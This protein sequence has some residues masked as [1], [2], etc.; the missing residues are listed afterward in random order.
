MKV[1]TMPSLSST[2]LFDKHMKTQL[3]CDTF[4]LIG[5]RGYDKNKMREQVNKK[6]TK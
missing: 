4:T 1:N 3:I 6:E 5:I 2:S